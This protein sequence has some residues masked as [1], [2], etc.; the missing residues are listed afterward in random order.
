MTTQRDVEKEQRLYEVYHHLTTKE[1]RLI[2]KTIRRILEL[3]D[4]YG[5]K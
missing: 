5:V 1:L 2:E 3:R 4:E